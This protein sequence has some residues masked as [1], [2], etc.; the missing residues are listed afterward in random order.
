M[1]YIASYP[2]TEEAVLPYVNRHVIGFTHLGDPFWGVV[3]A[4]KDGHIHLSPI[5]PNVAVTQATLNRL[6]KAKK[7][8]KQKVGI[9]KASLKSK[10]KVSKAALEKANISLYGP[11]FGYGYGYGGSAFAPG[12]GF[13]LGAGIGF[14]LPLLAISALFLL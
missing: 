4:C 9:K 12:F 6:Q 2:I 11:S 10:T 13:G 1:K 8:H 5:N 3:N 7:K 14:A